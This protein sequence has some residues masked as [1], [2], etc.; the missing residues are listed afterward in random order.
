[1]PTASQHH[2]AHALN[3]HEQFFLVDCG[4]G[5][6]AQLMRYGINPM[7]INAVFITHLHG[8]HFFGLYGLVSTLGLLGRRTPLPVFAPRPLREVLECHFRHFDTQLPYEV[9]VNEV[10]ATKHECIYENRMMQVW[11]VPLRH[12]VPCTG[13]LFREKPPGLN[14]HKEAIARYGLGIAQIAAAKRGEDITLGDG[15]VVA[16]G[17]LTYRPYRARSYAYCSDTMPSGKVASLVQGADLLYHEATFAAEDKKLAAQTGHSTAAQAAKVA[18][19]AGA[20][21]L[22]IGHCS[23]RYKGTDVLLAEAREVFPATSDA[24]EGAVFDIRTTPWSGK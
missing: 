23:N 15:T 11:T 5:T 10:D 21:R 6:Q 12:R 22:L 7:K 14:I 16:N 1:M 20:G 24:A 13:Y 4:E 3:V 18:V 2:S 19:Q 17:E 8:D 9:Q